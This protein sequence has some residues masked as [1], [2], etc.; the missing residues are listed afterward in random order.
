[1]FRRNVE[2]EILLPS[3]LRNG[4][5]FKVISV[6]KWSSE[7]VVESMG[8]KPRSHEITHLSVELRPG[9]EEQRREDVLLG[10]ETDQLFYEL[11]KAKKEEKALHQRRQ[12]T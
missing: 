3:D 8:M 1:M 7:F 2:I 11:T 6:A 10:G 12:N 9:P 5:S 4:R